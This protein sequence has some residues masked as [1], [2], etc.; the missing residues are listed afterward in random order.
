MSIRNWL[1]LFTQRSGRSGLRAGSASFYSAS[2]KMQDE[3]RRAAKRD[4][5][6]ARPGVTD[7]S[8]TPYEQQIVEMSRQVIQNQA[9]DMHHNDALLIPDFL[10]ARRDFQ[11]AQLAYE[12]KRRELGGRPLRTEMPYWFYLISV[13]ILM[14]GEV[15]VNFV[16]FQT[17]FPDNRILTAAAAGALGIVLLIASHLVGVAV[18]QRKQWLWAAGTAILM[19]A[20]T[21]SLAALRMKYVET[22]NAEVNLMG[23]EMGVKL[24]QLTVSWFFFLFNMIFLAV[25]AWMAAVT[26]DPD[27]DYERLGREYRRARNDALGCKRERDG[28]REKFLGE[29][30]DWVGLSRRL[31]GLYREENLA[32]RASKATPQVWH[33]HTLESVI[34]LDE[35]AFDLKVSSEIGLLLD[36]PGIQ[37]YQSTSAT[38]IE[39]EH[40]LG[41]T[42]R[43]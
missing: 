4:G 1:Q 11:S 12:K 31:L 3:A 21:A 23:A 42:V 8:L 27:A 39:G 15:G 9:S 19:I 35:K 43:A 24:D 2:Q 5:E 32:A 37:E 14:C 29:A 18:R 41:T 25:A 16:A 26:H 38:T 33:N 10:E 34:Q 17:I 20:I 7:V 40:V 28:N 6:G 30:R 13:V 22:H 36:E